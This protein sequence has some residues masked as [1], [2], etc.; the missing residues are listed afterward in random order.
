MPANRMKLG[1]LGE[2]DGAGDPT[3]DRCATTGSVPVTPS[4]KGMS[5]FHILIGASVPHPSLRWRREVEYPGADKSHGQFGGGC[6]AKEKRWFRVFRL[7]LGGCGS[8]EK[9]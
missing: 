3:T 1:M 6:S 8:K 2:P 7:D 5:E 9:R 4:T